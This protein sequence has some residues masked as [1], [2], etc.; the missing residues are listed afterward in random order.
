MCAMMGSSNVS[1]PN[2]TLSAL[3]MLP[4][5]IIVE[6]PEANPLIEPALKSIA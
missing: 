1:M 5:V 4:Q 6:E 3:S 2:A